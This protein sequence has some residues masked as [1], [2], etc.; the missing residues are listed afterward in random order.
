[1]IDYFRLLKLSPRVLIP[2]S[3]DVH[4]CIDALDFVPSPCIKAYA[5]RWV[6]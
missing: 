1:M 2:T 6:S 3:S 5:N 4:E